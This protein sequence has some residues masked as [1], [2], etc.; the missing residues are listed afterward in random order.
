[1]IIPIRYRDNAITSMISAPQTLTGA[2]VDV[3]A[4]IDTRD[5]YRVSLWVDLDINNSTD[6]RFRLVGKKTVDATDVFS[7]PIK[8]VLPASVKVEPEYYEFNVDADQKQLLDWFV[9]DM[10]PYVQVQTMVG[11]VGVTPGQLL[12]VDVTFASSRKPGA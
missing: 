2:W 12:S 10:A 9:A 8:T 7:L 5:I 1:M 11:A 4:P 3:G 6:V